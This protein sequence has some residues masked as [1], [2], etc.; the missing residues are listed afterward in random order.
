MKNFKTKEI[1]VDVV[2][3][4]L[5]SQRFEVPSDYHFNESEPVNAYFK[6]VSEY[7]SNMPNLIEKVGFRD[8]EAN[9]VIDV[10]FGC[11]ADFTIE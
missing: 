5:V 6:I 11:I 8:I 3:E 2:M 9:E 10:E 7:G 1:V 4:V